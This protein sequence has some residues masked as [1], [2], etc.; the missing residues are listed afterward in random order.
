MNML[1]MCPKCGTKTEVQASHYNKTIKTYTRHSKCPKCGESMTTY[2]LS[3]EAYMEMVDCKAKL[4]K[5]RKS[6]A[7]EMA[8]MILDIGGV[9]ES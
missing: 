6:I 9:D 2:E 1:K 7:K 3:K 8:K 4:Q 5:G